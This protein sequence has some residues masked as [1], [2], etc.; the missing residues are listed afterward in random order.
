MKLLFFWNQK[1]S[2]IGNFILVSISYWFSPLPLSSWETTDQH[3]RNKT[4]L[5]HNLLRCSFCSIAHAQDRALQDESLWSLQD[6]TS[7]YQLLLPENW[8]SHRDLGPGPTNDGFIP[9]L[10][11]LQLFSHLMA[12]CSPTTF[13]SGFTFSRIRPWEFPGSPMVR[14]A[15]FHKPQSIAKKKYTDKTCTDMTLKEAIKSK[16]QS[17]ITW[18]SIHS[19]SSEQKKLNH[20][21]RNKQKF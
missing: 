20:I 5:F 10:V 19:L 13:L 15:C 21:I 2:N 17:L 1:R 11:K 6:S 3:P 7:V 16:P 8:A 14:T 4:V 12:V 18:K 9:P